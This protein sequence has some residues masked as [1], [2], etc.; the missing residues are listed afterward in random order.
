MYD[1]CALCVAFD[2]GPYKSSQNCKENCKFNTKI[3]KEFSYLSSNKTFESDRLKLLS[4]NSS[5]K[6]SQETGNDFESSLIK[7][8]IMI[9]E[10]NCKYEFTIIYVF[11]ENTERIFI[12]VLKDK[13]CPNEQNIFYFNWFISIV[14]FI[15]LI[16]LLSLI[17]WR[18]IVS[19]KD[20]KDYEKWIN[21]LKT[22]EFTSTGQ[23]PLYKEPTTQ[24]KNPL[25]QSKNEN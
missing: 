25:Y 17:I 12:E 13:I 22:R 8:C 1:P 7:R 3:V 19:Y 10:D 4:T 15:I 11:K 21:Y 18:A 23:N 20:K 9:D 16:G 6:N 24:I 5:L 2:A 14:I